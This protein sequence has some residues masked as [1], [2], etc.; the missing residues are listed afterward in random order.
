MIITCPHCQTK[1]QVTY[2][3]IGAAG[4]KVQCAH[5]QQAWRQ[6]PLAPPPAEPEPTE[7]DP[8]TE[9]SLD[10]AMEA[11]ER[12]A[13][14]AKPRAV[15]Q[16]EDAAPPAGAVDPAVVRQRQR[17]FTQRQSAINKQMPLA[18]MR[19]GL[20]VLGVVAILGS[21]VFGFWARVGI[22]EQYPAMAG[23]YSAIGLPV[24]V[25]GL[26][27]GRVTTLQ[28]LREG[29]EVLLVSAELVG[30]T[31]KPVEVPPIVVTLLDAEGTG[32][33]EWSA[34]AST[35]TLKAG[36]HALVETQLSLPPEQAE[37]VRLSFARGSHSDKP[38][39]HLASDGDA[40][41]GGEHGAAGH[42][43]A[44]EAGHGAVGHER[45]AEAGHGS[46]AEA[47]HATAGH[48]SPAEAEHAAEA[49][50][51]HGPIGH[52]PAA[53]AEHG[54]A[55]HGGAAEHGSTEHGPA[56]HEPAEDVDHSPA[57]AAE[58]AHEVE[59]H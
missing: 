6:V 57:Q 51:G 21:L 30:V 1:Y 16:P 54:S 33:Y 20:R 55:E 37:R 10:E 7:I 35:S 31:G 15:P 58:D 4:R 29:K 2:E 3:A 36:E 47:E 39:P 43:P 11:E 42:E 48:G 9:D 32:I 56:G 45:A 24:N 52:E 18:R 17:D 40:E 8:I 23:V 41:A 19:R 26:D 34:V 49:D 44:T 38:L 28:A 22:V 14:R 13:S 46:A 5:C 59:Q 50:A 12:E 53:E 27:F 25:V